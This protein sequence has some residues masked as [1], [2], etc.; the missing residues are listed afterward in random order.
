MQNR[1]P[2]LLTRALAMVYSFPCYVT[3]TAENTPHGALTLCEASG[4]SPIAQNYAR[5]GDF[6]STKRLSPLDNPPSE[7]TTTTTNLFCPYC[8]WSGP[9]EAS[10]RFH[11]NRYHEVVVAEEGNRSLRE[12]GDKW[13]RNRRWLLDHG[14]VKCPWN[15]VP[16][17]T[18]VNPLMAR[19]CRHI[20]DCP[21]QEGS[22]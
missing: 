6:M 16:C 21:G 2:V 5:G 15:T 3:I 1:T 20:N 4:A 7:K 10:L 12:G 11:I 18:K 9:G 17:P 13:E 22:Q 14:Y 8:K 19:V